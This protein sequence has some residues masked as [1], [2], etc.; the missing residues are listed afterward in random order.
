MWNI[1][2]LR[3]Q[4]EKAKKIIND[5][6]QKLEHRGVDGYYSINHDIMD[7]AFRIWKHSHEMGVLKSMEKDIIEA[8]QGNPLVVPTRD[9]ADATSSF[10]DPFDLPD[11]VLSSH[12]EEADA[13]ANIPSDDNDE[14]VKAEA[15]GTEE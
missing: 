12:S 11:G 7:C 9:G 8:L 15:R 5:D 10:V 14:T 6:L 2:S 4:L 13:I 1:D 3:I